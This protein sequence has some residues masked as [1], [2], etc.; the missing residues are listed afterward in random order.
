MQNIISF[1][2]KYYFVHSAKIILVHPKY[3][4]FLYCSPL[5]YCSSNSLSD[6][7]STLNLCFIDILWFSD[8][9]FVSVYGFFSLLRSILLSFSIFRYEWLSLFTS[10]LHILPRFLTYFLY[11]FMIFFSFA[12]HIIIALPTFQSL[13][14]LPRFIT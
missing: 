7:F 13:F 5:S 12:L 14:F 10:L 8:I 3:W 4:T 9:F 11:H 2:N 6:S 1:L